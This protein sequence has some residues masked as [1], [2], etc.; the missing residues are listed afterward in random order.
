MLRICGEALERSLPKRVEA[1]SAKIL[2]ATVTRHI[3]Q[4]LLPDDLTV[5]EQTRGVGRCFEKAEFGKR[6]LQEH[7]PDCYFLAFFF[8]KMA[9]QRDAREFRPE[10]IAPGIQRARIRSQIRVEIRSKLF[11][12]N[13]PRTP[14]P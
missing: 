10:L 13:S 5:I 4:Q 7:P 11:L 6:I 14:V 8:L 9:G 12:Y 1:E 3:C 2:V